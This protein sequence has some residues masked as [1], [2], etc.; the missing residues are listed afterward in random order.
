MSRVMDGNTEGRLLRQEA[1][2]FSL[3]PICGLSK[4]IQESA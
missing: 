2:A 1:A 4:A 3:V